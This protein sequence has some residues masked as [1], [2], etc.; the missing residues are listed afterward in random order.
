MADGLSE[1][2]SLGSDSRILEVGSNDGYLLQYFQK[3]GVPILGVEPTRNIAQEAKWRG[4]LTGLNDILGSRPQTA[5]RSAHGSV[6]PL[7]E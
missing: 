2:F 5:G 1:R 4:F 6:T 7:A 3:R